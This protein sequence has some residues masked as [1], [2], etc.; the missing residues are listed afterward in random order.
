[1]RLSIG[2]SGDRLLPIAF[3]LMA[4]VALAGTASRQTGASF[5]TT[6]LNP[7]NQVATMLVQ[8]PASQNNTTSAVA[9]VVGLSWAATPTA[10]GGGHTLTYNVLRGPIGGPYVLIGNT[11]SLAY[12]DTPPADGTYQY[13]IQAK[14]TGGGTFTSGNSAAKNGISDRVLPTR[15]ITCNTISCAGWFKGTVSVT[16]TGTDAGT[17]MGSV[18]RNVDAAGQISTGGASV[19]FNVTGQSNHTVGY[20][21]TD[22]AGNASSSTNQ[23]VRIDNTAPT[24]SNAFTGNQGQQNG[25]IALSWTAGTDARSG[26]AGYVIRRA[27]ATTCPA[28]TPA[29]YPTNVTV[30]AVT[31]YSWTGLTSGTAYCFYIQTMDNA[32][33]LS[34]ASGS[35]GS[36]QAP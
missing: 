4:M 17:G 9:G 20:F 5:T 10:P 3:L 8:V 35:A 23:K 34:V 30:G 13:V 14:V 31:S 2:T 29:N 24:K 25:T 27:T 12:N 6:S 22:A 16:V 32:G 1:M 21:G 33:N 28:Q 11:A 19:T 36:F 15:S 26:L 18:T 7:A